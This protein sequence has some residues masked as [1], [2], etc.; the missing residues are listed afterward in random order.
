M[1]KGKK[2]YLP[3]SGAKLTRT[4][5]NIMYTEHIIPCDKLSENKMFVQKRHSCE[6]TG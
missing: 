2:S 3:A 4:V 1:Q 6:K 5:K